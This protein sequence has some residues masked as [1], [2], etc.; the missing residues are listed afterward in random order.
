M[1]VLPASRTLSDCLRDWRRRSLTRL[2]TNSRWISCSSFWRRK[3]LARIT[4]KRSH[5]YRAFCGTRILARSYARPG[6]RKSFTPCSQSQRTVVQVRR[7]RPRSV[8]MHSVDA[9]RGQLV[10]YGRAIGRIPVIG[11][12]E[13]APITRMEHV[14][15]EIVRNANAG[16]EYAHAPRL[17]H[18]SRLD[19]GD[20]RIKEQPCC[21][22]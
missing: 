9:E 5:A 10:L 15:L 7:H 1:D 2:W 16:R 3:A 20:V 8:E 13:H 14:E 21:C 19:I 22:L 17:R 18:R 6:A 12:A 4:C 11:K